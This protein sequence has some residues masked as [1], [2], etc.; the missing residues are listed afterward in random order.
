MEQIDSDYADIL[1]QHGLN[2]YSQY[3][4]GKE[5]KEWIITTTS[6]EAHNNIV[7]PLMRKDFKN[8]EIKKKGIKVKIL[9]KQEKIINKHD[10]MEEFYEKKAD[11]FIKIELL[12]PN[13]FRSAGKY[14]NFPTLRLV[15]QSL[16]N[17]YSASA[18][19]IEMFD[20]DTLE[21]LVNE[22]DIAGYKLRSTMFPLEG[23][24]IPSFI[25]SFTIKVNGSETMARYIRLL[26][27]FGE[28][29]GIGIKT[30]M[31]MGAISYKEERNDR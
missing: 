2:P 28:Y 24:K 11:R 6:E 9:E 1:H 5:E 15:Y 29:S 8:F 7:E 31:G 16:M 27:R 19:N 17:K 25:G 18:E 26:T 21:Q 14:I 30:A 10:L 20:E 4:I 22:S 3:L 12:T 23:V 13:S